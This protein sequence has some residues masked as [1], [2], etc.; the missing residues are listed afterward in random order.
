V[1]EVAAG[2]RFAELRKPAEGRVAV[3]LVAAGGAP[4]R[5]DDVCRRTDFG[6]AAAEVDDGRALDGGDRSDACEERA[7]VLLGQPVEAF[8]ARLR[9]SGSS[10]PRSYADA[11]G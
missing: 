2:D 8:R 11:E 9:R 10:P 3:D 4:E 5:L 6:I 7:E 1:V